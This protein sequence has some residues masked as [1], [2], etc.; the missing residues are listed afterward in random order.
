MTY[1]YT[2]SLVEQNIDLFPTRKTKKKE[3]PAIINMVAF[4]ATPEQI[5]SRLTPLQYK[6]TQKKYTEK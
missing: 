5:K 3:K 2:V 4:E 1:S 6:V